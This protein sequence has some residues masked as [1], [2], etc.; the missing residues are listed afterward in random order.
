MNEKTNFYVFEKKEILLITV[1]VLLVAI[2]SFLFGLKIGSHYS[3]DSSG[4]GEG[5]RQAITT[6]AQKVD[7]TSTEEEKVADILEK[8]QTQEQTADGKNDINEKIQ[9]SLKQKMLEE[10]S[11]ENKKFNDDEAS[12]APA[13]A[14][15]VAAKPEPIVEAPA[16]TPVVEEA[17]AV[18]ASDDFSGKYTIQLAS[19]QS[20][21]E[22]KDFAEGFKVLGFNPI[23]NEAELPGKGNWFRVSLGVFDNISQAKDF[24]MKNKSVFAERD[25]VFIQFD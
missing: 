5:E 14:P 2:T 23:I 8:Q 22:A 11:N 16:A 10:F 19:Y 12:T 21:A 24:V 3:F 20:L 7:L 6:E 25:Y 4:L 17:P 13:P 9:E 18:P 15:S 1:L